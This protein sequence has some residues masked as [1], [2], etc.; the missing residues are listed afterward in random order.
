M[1]PKTW[2]ELAA[3]SLRHDL[4]SED[5]IARLNRLVQWTVFWFIVV[6]TIAVYLFFAFVV[7]EWWG[8]LILAV[9]LAPLNIAIYQAWRGRQRTP[10]DADIVS[11]LEQLNSD[12]SSK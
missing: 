8:L 10:E 4:K 6:E 9:L 11:R 7:K 1:N 3:G 2:W 5:E 12:Q